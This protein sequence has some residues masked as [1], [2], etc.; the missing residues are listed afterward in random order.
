[1]AEAAAEY[2]VHNPQDMAATIKKLEKEMMQHATNLEFEQAAA[3]R[4]TITELK[5]AM[6]KPAL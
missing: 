4:D 1:M 5:E 2:K 3:V 6:L